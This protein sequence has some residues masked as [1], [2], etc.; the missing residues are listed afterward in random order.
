MT[1]VPLASLPKNSSTL[2]TVR[3]N[4]T[5]LK[6]WSFILRM[7]FWP[8]TARPIKAMSAVGCMC[9]LSQNRKKTIQRRA[10]RARLFLEDERPGWCENLTLETE[11][12]HD[13]ID[14]KQQHDHAFQQ[15]HPAIV[16]VSF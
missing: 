10:S 3:L 16:L 13:Q 6:P 12:E 11:E 8:M 4:A 2:E 7:R 15:E 1:F 5:T 9:L 14:H